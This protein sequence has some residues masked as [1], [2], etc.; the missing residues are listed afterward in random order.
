MASDT[1]MLTALRDVEEALTS[2][3]KADPEAFG[4]HFGAM[5]HIR[6]QKAILAA[7]ESK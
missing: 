5:L 3:H 6:I 1:K 7:E 4:E 2:F